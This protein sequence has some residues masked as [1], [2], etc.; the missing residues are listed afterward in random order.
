MVSR[1]IPL[2][3][4]LYKTGDTCRVSW[5]DFNQN[6]ELL[7]YIVLKQIVGVRVDVPIPSEYLGHFRYRWGFLILTS[8]ELP[9]GLARF[10]VSLWIRKPKSLWLNS[11]V[12]LRTFLRTVPSYWLSEAEQKRDRHRSNTPWTEDSYRSDSAE[13]DYRFYL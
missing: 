9:I 13:E 10:L 11:P 6:I 2:S 4:P 5:R 3:E 8:F 1:G 7:T 12:A